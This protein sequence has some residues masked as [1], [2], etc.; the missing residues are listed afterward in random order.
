MLQM[1]ANSVW[2]IAEVD[3]PVN[4]TPREKLGFAL[5]YAALSPTATNWQP[6]SF[7]L[8]DTQ[9]EIATT[10]VTG[11]G[12]SDP[13]ER[14]LLIGCG[15][16]IQY[17]K[18]A[19]KHFGC[20]GRMELFPDLDELRRVARIH[21]G[22][23]GERDALE[24]SLFVAMT[25]NHTLAPTQSAAPVSD[26]ILATLQ[27]SATAERGWLEFARSESLRQRVAEIASTN[28]PLGLIHDRSDFRLTDAAPRRPTMRWP[29]PLS[30]FG[31]REVDLQKAEGGLPWPLPIAAAT[32]AVVKTK[33]DDKHGWLAAGQTLARA[34]LQ[35]QAL[36]LSWAFFNHM[37]SRQAR[38]ELRSGIGHKGFAQ[39]ILQFGA[40][41]ESEP[42][43]LNA[44]TTATATFR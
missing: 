28:A 43:Q 2:T 10:D 11:S 7:Q 39:V 1:S 25:E 23:G 21:F 4:G 24:R 29:R 17:L 15:A 35:A 16:A 13:E 14:E 3:F 38:E 42:R 5:K 9:L 34:V 30:A 31:R 12:N 8:T 27:L 32:L 40:F 33:T 41:T 37:R 26:A 19:M 20:W 22:F 6:W 36:R 44:P 18:L